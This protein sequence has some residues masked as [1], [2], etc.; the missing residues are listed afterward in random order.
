MTP[1]R[2]Q[3][4]RTVLGQRQPDLRVMTDGVHKA[5]NL[6][7]ILRTCDASGVL[8]LHIAAASGQRTGIW[9]RSA[10]GSARWVK[11]HVHS[12]GKEAAA[13]LKQAGFKLYA[14]HL[15][16]QA[17]DYRDVDYTLPCAI[18]MGAEKEGVSAEVIAEIDAEITIP[19]FGMVESYN[20]SVAAALI[21]SEAQQQRQ[22]AGLYQGPSRLPA[23][24]YTATLFE[25][26]HP[27]MARYCQQHSLPYPPLDDDGDIA[28]PSQW[29]ADVRANRIRES[30]G[31]TD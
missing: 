17:V 6:S 14:A 18:V 9:K 24:E 5:Q 25:W 7:A 16:A 27:K 21:L 29:Y 2:F 10:G 3:K 8:N 28:N 13:H 15:S 12:S 4:I 30:I 22:R 19:M 31:A 11:R 26:C 20:V 23:D 1:E